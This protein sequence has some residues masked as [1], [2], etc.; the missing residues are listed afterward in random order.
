MAII[1]NVMFCKSR[2]FYCQVCKKAAIIRRLEL[3]FREFLSIYTILLYFYVQDPV[4]KLNN[5]K[6]SE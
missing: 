5:T 3:H 1:E 4:E 6:F 2:V